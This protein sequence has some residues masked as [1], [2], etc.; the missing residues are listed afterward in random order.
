MV[1]KRTITGRQAYDALC[2][3]HDNL[4]VPFEW[5]AGTIGGVAVILQD[6]GFETLP[7]DVARDYDDPAQLRE[8][9]QVE[10]GYRPA[11]D[12]AKAATLVEQIAAMDLDELPSAGDGSP[13]YDEH[14]HDLI[15]EARRI[16]EG[17]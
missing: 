9:D 4:S 13:A 15:V 17:S 7:E 1:S 2:A 8:I 5:D 6:Y 11:Y 14:L 3:I 16:V 10:R 12:P